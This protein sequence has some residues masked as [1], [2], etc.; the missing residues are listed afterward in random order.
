MGRPVMTCNYQGTN[1]WTCHQWSLIYADVPRVVEITQKRIF[2]IIF[3]DFTKG[4]IHGSHFS[5]FFAH[6]SLHFL[7]IFT[8]RDFYLAVKTKEKWIEKQLKN[9]RKTL[10]WAPLI[11]SFT[12]T[13]F[14]SFFMSFL[15]SFFWKMES[16]TSKETTWKT[17]RKTPFFKNSCHVCF[18]CVSVFRSFFIHFSCSG[19]KLPKGVSA[20]SVLFLLS[21]YGNCIILLT[22]HTT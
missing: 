14:D 9:G 15:I 4:V 1:H 12:V 2:S 13:V 5:P 10:L 19:F 17:T 20:L 11:V 6:F 22:D 8:A 18:W 7:L 16:K 3:R 21:R